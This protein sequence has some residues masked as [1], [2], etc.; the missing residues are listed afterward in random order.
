MSRPNNNRV[1]LIVL[2]LIFLGI[3]VIPEALIERHPHFA[4]EKIPLF[5]P[6]LGFSAVV[7]LVLLA[8]LLKAI[9]G[10]KEGHYD[11]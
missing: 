5:F 1:S 9:L 6:L 2:G 11:D 8:R 7:V 10:R 4:M 3:L